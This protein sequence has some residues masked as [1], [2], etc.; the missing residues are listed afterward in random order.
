MKLIL[1]LFICFF[2]IHSSYA[3]VSK[4]CHK[5]FTDYK[6]KQFTET[7]IRYF[8][9]NQNKQNEKKQNPMRPIINKLVGEKKNRR[10]IL[11]YLVTMGYLKL[12]NT[13]TLNPL[14]DYILSKPSSETI[15]LIKENPSFLYKG[16]LM[17]LSPFFL[18]VFIGDKKVMEAAIE[19]DKKQIHSRT[20]MEETT[21]HYTIDQEIATALLYYNVRPNATR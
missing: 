7:V 18:I 9:A 10:E 5:V 14:F 2:Y 21:L 16:T 15:Q 4:N 19:V 12:E 1:F 3:G 17:G 11:R 13:T 8:S 20:K 6:M